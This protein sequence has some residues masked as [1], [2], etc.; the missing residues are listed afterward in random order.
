MLTRLL[1]RFLRP[2][3]R[4]VALVVVLLALQAAGNLYLPNLNADIINKGVVAGD[5]GAIWRYGGEMLGV[6]LVLGVISVVAV[7]FASRVA[8][9]AGADMRKAVFVRVQEFSAREMNRFGTPSLITRNTNDVQQVQIFTQAALTLIVIAPIMAVGGVIMAVRESARLSVLLAVA[10]PLMLAVIAAIVRVIVPRFRSMQT[11]IDRINL[12]LREQITGVRVIRAFVRGDSETE[13]FGD[14]NERLTD[15]A[16]HVNRVFALAIPSVLLVM[17]LSSVAVIW[18]GGMLVRDDA[19]PVGNLTAFL[20]YIMQI[21]MSVMMAVWLTILQPRAS[22]SAERIEQVL[23]TQP[24]VADPAHPVAPGRRTGQVELQDVD[25]RYPGSELP[26]LRG[27]TFSLPPGE[28]TAIIGGTGSGKTT[29]LNLIPRFFDA[30]SG[31][32]LV[33]GVDVREQLLED[34]WDGIAI[35]PQAS[36]LFRG[37]VASNLRLGRPDASDDEL[38]HALEI[39]QARHFVATMPGGL[40][41]AIDQGGTNVSGGQRQRLSIARAL[42]KRPR[43]Y[44]FDDCFSALD[45]ATDAALRA[46]LAAET[47]DATVAIVSQRV[48]TIQEA[49]SIVVLDE[50]RVAGVGS[51]ETLLAGCEPYR[52]IVDSQLGREAA[53]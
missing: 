28:T 51:H 32:V 48:S 35:V 4:P 7:Y 8:M 33:D 9:G 10:V 2:Y 13:R 39:A 17:N 50:G 42:V 3:A 40:D 41:A 12:V 21:L 19:L 1:R 20:A 25:F 18:F 38:W 46:A 14:A 6:T 47:G 45:G 52:E 53:A 23:D 24:S 26:V 49:D 36:F 37:T 5:L 15:T 16:L 27:I 29:L 34:L 31:R 43:V 44:L 11:Q 30:S 22:A